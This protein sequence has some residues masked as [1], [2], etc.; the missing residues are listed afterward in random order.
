MINP[1][2]IKAAVESL[3]D[4]Y[5]YVK[6][7]ANHDPKVTE[8]LETIR[9]KVLDAREKEFELLEKI[10]ELQEALKTK[11]MPF[12]R[13]VETYYEDGEDKARIYYCLRCADADGKKCKLSGNYPRGLICR[14]CGYEYSSKEDAEKTRSEDA[15]REASRPQYVINRFPPW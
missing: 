11:S 8:T 4:L 12:D 1:S 2:E 13:D 5:N 7:T 9:I 6:Q 3:R 15:M 14:V 10:R